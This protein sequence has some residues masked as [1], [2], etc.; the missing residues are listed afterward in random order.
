MATRPLPER[1]S[2]DRLRRQ[3]REVQRADGGPLHPAQLAV[4]R[5]YGFASWTRMVRGIE[6]ITR[7]RRDS[8]PADPDDPI[9][10]FCVEGVLTYRDADGPQRWARARAALAADPDLLRRDVAAAAVAADPNA[11]AGH[12]NRDPAA[13]TRDAGPLRWPPLLYLAYSRL[14]G[15]NSELQKCLDL[16]LGDANAG[17]FLDGLPT[18]FTALTGVFGSA[19]TDRPAHPHHEWFAQRLLRA[20]ADPNDGQ[21][22]YNRMFVPA[23]DH[24]RLLFAHGLGTG[25]GGIWHR[26]LPEVTET[27]QVM[28]S[29][30]LAWAVM[31]GM[32][33]RVRLLAENGV[34]L[35]API[36]V[37]RIVGTPSATPLQL[38]VRSGQRASIDALRELGV[39][40]LDPESR[41]IDAL[42]AGRS[43]PTSDV[44]RS[45]RRYPSL[46]LR[47]A[48]AGNQTGVRRLVEAGFDVNAYGRQDTVIEQE[49][50]TALHH[51][52]GEGKV[53]ITELLLQLGADPTLRDRR[54]DSTPLDWAEH[55]DQPATAAL[56]RAYD[57]GD[58]RPTGPIPPEMI[59]AD[60][61]DQRGEGSLLQG[62]DGAGDDQQ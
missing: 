21:A 30:Q 51:A 60:E 35:R 3:A 42:L 29:A 33:D 55:L 58:S 4:A 45:R 22:L 59:S 18:P 61:D 24:L 38:A 6:E 15:G 54:F 14:G 27:P 9:G 11:L 37:A 12:L 8:L 19:T 47:A 32:A 2:I 10:A 26:R 50:E 31:H 53:E 7:F 49:W 20:G 48:V 41:L 13:A 40:D 57:V 23:D 56:L 36:E 28:L 46:V 62:A 16:L 17:F 43:V 5:S 39:A 1:P 52:A 25:D 44:D 34:D